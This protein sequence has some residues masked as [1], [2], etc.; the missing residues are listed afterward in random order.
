MEET[1][2]DIEMQFTRVD[3]A[4]HAR[5]RQLK[6]EYDGLKADLSSLYQEWEELTEELAQS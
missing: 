5:Q 1:V 2:E 6:E 3:P 4:D